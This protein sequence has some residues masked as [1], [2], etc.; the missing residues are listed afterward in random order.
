MRHDLPQIQPSREDPSSE[1][2]EV[3]GGSRGG[4][5]GE[6]KVGIASVE[7]SFDSRFFGSLR[8]SRRTSKTEGEG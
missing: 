6:G 1:G 4:F 7:T 3:V 2:D 5:L 8:K